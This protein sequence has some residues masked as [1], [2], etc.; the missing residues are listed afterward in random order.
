MDKAWLNHLF[1]RVPSNITMPYRVP[2]QTYRPT[3]T[4]KRTHKRV[5][6]ER[7]S[8][9]VRVK[10]HYMCRLQGKCHPNDWL[11]SAPF[12]ALPPTQ[13]PSWFSI[14]VH[15]RLLP[16]RV[17][18]NLRSSTVL[19]LVQSAARKITLESSGTSSTWR[20]NQTIRLEYK[21]YFH[22]LSSLWW[23]GCPRLWPLP[24]CRDYPA[25][26]VWK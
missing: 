19:N 26:Q 17:L 21:Y 2:V 11:R 14:N 3:Q 23:Q 8:E 18:R 7:V 1:N 10:E 25:R 24:I 12:Q 5:H 9:C 15:P 13:S 20:E 4:Q 6:R 22:S 16:L